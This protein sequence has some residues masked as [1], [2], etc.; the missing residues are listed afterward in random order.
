MLQKEFTPKRTV[1]KVTFAIP[2]E[3]AKKDVAIA[4]EFNNWDTKSDK[5]TKKDGKWETL[6][7]LKPNSEYRYKFLLDGQV[8]ENDDAADA[9]VPNEFGTEDSLVK[10][11]D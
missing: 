5:L 10:V 7:R 8:W 1:C 2:E 6:L 4:G 3:W 11:G 9:Y